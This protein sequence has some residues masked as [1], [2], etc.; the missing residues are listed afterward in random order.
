MTTEQKTAAPK[1]LKPN[2][3]I[4]KLRSRGFTVPNVTLVS[5]IHK[6]YLPAHQLVP[7]GHKFIDDAEVEKMLNRAVTVKAP[8]KAS[9]KRIKK[10]E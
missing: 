6:G 2:E 1:Y 5:W 9:V 4:E 8:V 7:G 10:E 3:V